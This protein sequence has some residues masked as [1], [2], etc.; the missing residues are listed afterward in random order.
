MPAMALPLTASLLR[1]LW[2]RLQPRI[3]PA[4]IRG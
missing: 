4:K 3:K 2:E 1:I